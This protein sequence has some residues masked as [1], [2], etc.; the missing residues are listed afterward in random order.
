MVEIWGSAG[1]RSYKNGMNDDGDIVDGGSN[2]EVISNGV[3][4]E[5]RVGGRW[6]KLTE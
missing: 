2:G 3:I 6:M 1:D 5:E 4:G